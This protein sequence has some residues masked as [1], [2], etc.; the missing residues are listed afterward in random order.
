MD[1]N[2]SYTKTI[3][4]KTSLCV[5]VIDEIMII[6]KKKTNNTDIVKKKRM[7]LLKAQ[8]KTLNKKYICLFLVR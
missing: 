3:S 1:A 8:F 2:V 4:Q 6:L 5:Q 7:M